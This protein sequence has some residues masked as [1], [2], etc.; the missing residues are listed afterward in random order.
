M[1]RFLT[2]LIY[3]N[4]VVAFSA[5]FLSAGFCYQQEIENWVLYGLFSFFSTLAVYNGQ[6]IFK[7]K[8][9]K[10]T[11]WLTWVKIH[12]K[13]LIA[14]VFICSL[15]STGLFFFLDQNITTIYFLFILTGCISIL[16]VV[17]IKGR[18]MRELPF[19]KIHLIALSWVIVLILFPLLNESIVSFRQEYTFAFY[20]YVLAVTIPF[21][22]RDIKYDSPSQ[23]TIPQIMG[24]KFAKILSVLLLIVFFFI[25]TSI[26]PSL[27]INILFVISIII[28][29]FLLLLMNEKRGD[30]YCAGLI[31]GTIGLMGLSLFF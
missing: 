28:Q 21:D 22:I 3:T 27:R 18:N 10:E 26:E 2:Y 8:E 29:L 13:I 7:A 23:K 24:I 4:L 16:Y 17:R 31:D 19:I 1:K 11:E 12:H 30:F 9:N 14:F 6:R 20:C 15:F 25:I 5:G